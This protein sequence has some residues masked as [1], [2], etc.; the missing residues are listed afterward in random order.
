MEKDGRDRILKELQAGYNLPALSPVAFKLVEMASDD[1]S[2][3]KD[4]ADLI[5]KDPSLAV[6]L[7]K[8]ANSAFFQSGEPVSTLEQAVVK[9]GFQRI[10]VMG[11]SLSLRDTFP[12]GKVGAM[13]YERFWRSSLY[14][15]IIAKSLAQH[16]GNCNPDEAFV[17][18]LT[19][20]IGFLILFDIFFTSQP[21]PFPGD[22]DD[23]ERILPWEEDRLGINHREVGKAAL[24]FWK[25]PES[26]L[27]CQR[28]YGK[29]ALAEEAPPLA[30]VCELGRVLG[31]LLLRKGTDFPSLFAE[32]KRCGGLD[33]DLLNDI[34]LETFTQVQ[35]IADQLRLA[36]D[37]E[38]D[39]LGLMERANQAL[40]RISDHLSDKEKTPSKTSL[41]SF[42]SLQEEGA[43]V[44]T[45]TLQ[46]V[47]HEIRN[48]LVAVG[49][50]A[51]RLAST[52]DP[53]S[54][55]G[56]YAQ[57]ILEETR[58][59]EAALSRMTTPEG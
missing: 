37:G 29:E 19:L 3:A 17:G 18:A 53:S 7:L 13:D 58:R 55:G 23:L 52:L 47:A 16:R 15:A 10:R 51:K 57:F 20:E 54:E 38:K 49:G 35:E 43:L 9:L 33:S 22:P 4:L 26:I 8:I 56:K 50:F 12:M 34:L 30:R 39:L 31:G 14:R 6:R 27:A 21:E 1:S 24:S 25:F 11:L 59:L 36:L 2:S 44:V 40:S 48:P 5:G 45:R 28:L 42:E 41:P 32:A 46:A